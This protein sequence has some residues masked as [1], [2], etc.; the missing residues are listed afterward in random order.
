MKKFISEFKKEWKNKKYALCIGF[1]LFIV[2]GVFSVIA[3]L[4]M[5][6]N[7][8]C[9]HYKEVGIAFGIFILIFY[10]IQDHFAEK[11][12]E[13]EEAL[14]LARKMQEE[15]DAD[16]IERNY[17]LVRN[18]IFGVVRDMSD[19]LGIKKPVREG[20]I[21]SP[22][23]TILKLNFILYQ[24]IVYRTSATTDTET[25]RTILR[26]E[27]AR[28]IDAHLFAGISQDY[29]VYE[30]QAEPIISVYTVE[31]NNAYLT[32]SVAIADENYCRQIRQNVSLSLLQQAEQLT[33]PQDNDF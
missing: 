25:M 33:A 1:I 10:F 7:F 28:R 26:Q 24:Y 17:R 19:I 27:I 9:E 30:G 8:I 20:E 23:H 2:T 21:D 3:L 31:D 32:I 16:T 18:C 14:E 15:A 4:Y 6:I 11:R 12:R 5:L 22:N 13:R 29:Y